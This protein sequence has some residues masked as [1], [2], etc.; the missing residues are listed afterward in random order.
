MSRAGRTGFAAHL[1]SLVALALAM[2]AAWA[3]YSVHVE[4]STSSRQE[5]SGLARSAQRADHRRSHSHARPKRHRRHRTRAAR[6]R[7]HQQRRATAT[8]TLVTTRVV[9]RRCV[10][11]RAPSQDARPATELASENA[12][13]PTRSDAETENAVDRELQ[14]VIDQQIPP[15]AQ[16]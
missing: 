1:P 10:R 11:A 8:R 3:S 15:R 14:E 13:D 2:V 16:P 12:F 7:A 9:Q 4:R 6:G 5:A